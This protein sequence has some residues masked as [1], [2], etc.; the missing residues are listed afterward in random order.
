MGH[1]TDDIQ[2]VHV[3][4]H[5]CAQGH[6]HTMGYSTDD[7]QHIHISGFCRCSLPCRHYV[8][9]EFKDGT[10]EGTGASATDIAFLLA[11]IGQGYGL[12]VEIDA[13]IFMNPPEPGHFDYVWKESWL[14]GQIR[15]NPV[16]GLVL[17]KLVFKLGT[18]KGT[19]PKGE[20]SIWAYKHAK[21]EEPWVAHGWMKR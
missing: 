17:G 11:Y 15:V 9:V 3:G 4:W 16:N 20:A 10:H 19:L 1:S 12:Y 5:M 13:D 14:W 2:H 6:T 8:I 18:M 21:E 7:I